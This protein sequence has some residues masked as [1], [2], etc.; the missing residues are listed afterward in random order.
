M[1]LVS[2]EAKLDFQGTF[3]MHHISILLQSTF[4]VFSLFFACKG[5]ASSSAPVEELTSVQKRLKTL[6]DG[7]E[8]LESDLEVMK[9]QSRILIQRTTVGFLN[10]T[11]LKAGL[12]LIL[13]RKRTFSFNTDT[14]IGAY[15]GVGHYFGRQHVLE[16]TLDW[17]LYL[18]SSLRYRLE[19]HSQ[20]PNV[21][22]A[23]VLG[24][25]GKLASLAPFDNFLDQPDQVQTFFVIVGAMLGFPM[26]HSMVT[27]ECDLLLNGQSIITFN[28][29]AHFFL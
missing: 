15:A 17:D 8:R 21:T 22:L 10:A 11:Y 26:G 14:G 4:F 12:A 19:I 7:L 16:A 28:V 2:I 29:A 27:G 23:P 20:S 13:P 18:A 6:E 24:V 1:H 3:T 9:A 25:K 5:L